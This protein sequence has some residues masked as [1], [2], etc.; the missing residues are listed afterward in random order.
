MICTIYLTTSSY[1]VLLHGI[2]WFHT[3]EIPQ[4]HIWNCGIPHSETCSCFGVWNP[5]IAMWSCGFSIVWFHTALCL[6]S[7]RS[8]FLSR[9]EKVGGSY[10]PVPGCCSGFC[11]WH[12]SFA[13]DFI[14]WDWA[15]WID[16][17]AAAAKAKSKTGLQSTSSISQSKSLYKTIVQVF[18]PSGPRPSNPGAQTNVL[19][20]FVVCFLFSNLSNS[21]LH[22]FSYNMLL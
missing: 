9:S 6:C 2:V 22:D 10:K 3:I 20:L 17:A 1:K 12:P 21:D 18:V 5:T 13:I 16:I 4:F 14:S 15:S 8:I 7:S 19:M 11:L